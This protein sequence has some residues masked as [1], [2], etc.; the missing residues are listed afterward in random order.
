MLCIFVGPA[1]VDSL[2]DALGQIAV[3]RLNMLNARAWMLAAVLMAGAHQAADA[4]DE[5]SV[6]ASVD[7]RYAIGLGPFAPADRHAIDVVR[8]DRPGNAQASGSGGADWTTCTLPCSGTPGYT[9]AAVDAFASADAGV[10]RVYAANKV[11][12]TPSL[13]GPNVPPTPNIDSAYASVSASA[14]FTDHLTVEVAGLAPGTDVVVPMRYLVEFTGPPGY[15][16]PRFSAHPVDVTASFTIP[17]YRLQQFSSTS[18]PAAFLVTTLANGNNLFSLR[19]IEIPVPTRVGDVLT[20]GATIELYGTVE[21]G[22]TTDREAGAFLDARNTA[23]IWL[24]NLPAGMSIT[25]ASGHDYRIDPS[26]VV[27]I[28]EPASAVLLLSGLALL[29]RLARWRSAATVPS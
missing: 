28:P 18:T 20:V 12:A 29:G 23:G 11:T 6:S 25:S 7:G 1:P 4:A 5:F 27:A 24:G 10:L 13:N 9:S 19:S 14:S 2:L 17:G 26:S 8:D 3:G 15:Y 22:P 21:V 16:F